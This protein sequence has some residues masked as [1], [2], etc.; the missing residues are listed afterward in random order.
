MKRQIRKERQYKRPVT[1]SLQYLLHHEKEDG[2]A[3][4][5]LKYLEALKSLNRSHSTISQYR[6]ALY[7]FCSFAHSRSI[8]SIHEVG[9]AVLLAWQQEL[10]RRTS[11][12]KDDLKEE[13]KRPLQ[14]NTQNKLFCRVLTFLTWL[15]K[16]GILAKDP[17][18][19]IE[20]PRN[21]R[22]LPREWFNLKE[23]EKILAR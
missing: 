12:R 9:E 5:G 13:K 19:Q 6:W 3:T 10:S 1:R 20:L 4:L 17:G 21:A 23:V 16:K 18:E 22:I 2:I 8:F 7:E 14:V 11:R 15:C